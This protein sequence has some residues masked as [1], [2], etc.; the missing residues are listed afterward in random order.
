MLPFAPRRGYVLYMHAY[1]D[2]PFL[3]AL[4]EIGVAGISRAW[5]LSLLLKLALFRR[6][7]WCSRATSI[8]VILSICCFH[9][10]WYHFAL[11]SS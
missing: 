5:T 11:F 9:L 8:V 3:S 10:A 6:A 2:A 7:K 1:L 4:E